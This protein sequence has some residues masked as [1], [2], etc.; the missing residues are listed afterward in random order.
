[1]LTKTGPATVVAGTQ[2]T[3]TLSLTNN[4]PAA[5]QS[6][7]LSDTL[8][9]GE[10]FVSASTGTGSGTSYSS[11]SLGT[12]AAGASTTITL[13]AAVSPSA[14]NGTV[15]TN[16]ASATSTRRWTTTAILATHEAK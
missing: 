11:G 4:G 1:M 2:V 14:V 12:L 8:P 9:A 13:V 7:S 6:V 16:S 10:T 3:Y 5:A 15:L